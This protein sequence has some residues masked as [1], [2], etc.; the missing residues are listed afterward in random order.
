[1]NKKIYLAMVE[2]ILVVSA[3]SGC[4]N[5]DDVVNSN[6]LAESSNSQKEIDYSVSDENSASN[7]DSISNQN[8]ELPTK[9]K[10]YQQTVKSFTEE[11]LL[12]FFS[13]NPEKTYIE[14]RELTI[15][16]SETE[17]GNV[18][19]NGLNFF[20][21][22]GRLCMTAYGVAYGEGIQEKQ[23]NLAFSS[24][25]NIIKKAVEKL[26]DL[27]VS[28]CD[29]YINEMYAVSANDLEEFKEKVYNSA[30]EN[31]YSLDESELQ[32]E[33]EEAERIKERKAKDFYYI[34]IRPKFEDIPTYS[35]SSIYYGID[36][37]VVSPCSCRMCYSEDGIEY[38]S[39]SDFAETKS[40]KEVEIIRYEAAKTFLADK[41]NSI[42]FDGKTDILDIKL[43]YIPIPQNDLGNCAKDFETRPFYA[44]YYTITEEY[45]GEKNIQNVITYF[46]AV[47]GK[48]LGTESVS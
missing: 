17:N 7:I 42:I 11:Q 19:E 8:K 23:E 20:T 38:F 32:K 2:I 37:Y 44:F 3:I 22:T 43:V 9:C 13:A 18:G 33:I 14:S 27:G 28:D 39:V 16:N 12:S 26:K 31:P 48:E 36:D 21:N 10:I 46:D 29:W 15:Y 45:D 30:R 25:E 35:G 5:V 6:L 41:Y 24:R 34:E 47:T 1:M 4:A 40:F